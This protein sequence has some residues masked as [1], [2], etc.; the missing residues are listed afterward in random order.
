MLSK[1]REKAV[2]VTWPSTPPNQLS[3]AVGPDG[4]WKVKPNL[5]WQMDCWEDW[6]WISPL[7]VRLFYISVSS[8]FWVN[9]SRTGSYP[10]S[11]ITYRAGPTCCSR[12]TVK[13]METIFSDL[14]TQ[15][16]GW[17]N[18]RPSLPFQFEEEIKGHFWKCKIW[19]FRK[20]NNLPKRSSTSHYFFPN[21]PPSMVIVCA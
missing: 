8:S 13:V 21:L 1:A 12:T 17:V 5:I 16:Q 10:L 19:M 9:V 20:S 15:W 6:E 11:L 2:T 14:V 3:L 4:Q 18:S 7:G